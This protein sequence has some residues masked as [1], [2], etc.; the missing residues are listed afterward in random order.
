M[1][2]YE[3]LELLDG[4]F[5]S[6]WTVSQFGF[7]VISAY[8][9]L[10]Y[11]VGARLTSFQVTFV[12]ICFLVMNAVANFSLLNAFRRLEYITE[13]LSDVALEAMPVASLPVGVVLTFDAFLVIGCYAFMWSVRHPK[14]D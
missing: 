14:T 12:N 4:V 8:C 6:M 9:L 7:G 10:A 2:E 5:G 3:V 1:T 13:N 11:Y